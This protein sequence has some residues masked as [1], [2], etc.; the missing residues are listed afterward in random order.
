MPRMLNTPLL[1]LVS[2]RFFEDEAKRHASSMHA[3][4][5]VRFF[6]PVFRRRRCITALEYPRNR[7]S[8]FIRLKEEPGINRRGETRGKK[9]FLRPE[10]R[11]RLFPSD[12]P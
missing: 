7:K 12:F 1:S 5:F 10:T 8:Q 4:L 9:E 6:F 2:H 3:A 11:P